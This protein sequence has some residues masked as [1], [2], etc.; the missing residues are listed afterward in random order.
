MNVFDRQY[1]KYDAW[2]DKNRF[3]YLSELQALK[4]VLPKSGKGLEIGAGT[5]RF[6]GPLGITL[7]IDPS[8]EMLRLARQ[9]GVNMLLGFG[10]D[11]PF[12]H[13]TF[14]YVAII[15][16]M[17]FVNN[18][19]KVLQ[20]S[21]RVLKKNGQIIIGIVDKDSFLGK[22]Y[23][24]KK[25]SFYKEAN[26]FSVKELSGLLGS[27]GFQ[28]ISHYQTLFDLPEEINSVQKPCKGF[29]KGGFVVISG[30][31]A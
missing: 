7:G 1:K 6:T 23:Q 21:R 31:K 25:S 13:G 8:A 14:D 24:K 5:G 20:E 10:E 30:A 19:L 28:K 16:S 4:K 11:L 3:V 9:R 18:P 2:Y 29:G 22:F 27:L 17:C 26:F 12:L 15:I